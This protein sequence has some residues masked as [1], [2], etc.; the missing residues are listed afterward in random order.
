MSL[1][2]DEMGNCRGTSAVSKRCC[3]RRPDGPHAVDFGK[4]LSTIAILKSLLRIGIGGVLGAGGM[5]GGPFI[6]I[7]FYLFFGTVFF[8]NMNG[9]S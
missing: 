2:E 1:R 4:D 8:F 7:Y 6:I 3:I 9:G 5:G